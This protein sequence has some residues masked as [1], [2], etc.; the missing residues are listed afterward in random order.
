MEKGSTSQQ[1]QQSSEP[2]EWA[3][4][5]LEKVASEALKFYNQGEGYNVYRG[6]TVAEFSPQK[7]E[8]LN[9][10]LTMTGGGTPVT[11]AAIFGSQNPQVKA[12]QDLIAKQIADQKAR[13]AA[14]AATTTPAAA[15]PNALSQQDIWRLMDA[16]LGGGGS[17]G[18]ASSSG[19]GQVTG[20]SG[21][22]LY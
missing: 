1:T 5:L 13:A 3:R 8:G 14:T 11:N 2:P 19:A 16:R 21:R 15:Q 7:L 12:A 9:K 18:R 4:P 6:P 10:I 22:G 17:R 20:Y